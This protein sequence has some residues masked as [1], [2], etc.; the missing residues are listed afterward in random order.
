M[1]LN[2]NKVS[3]LLSPAGKEKA[4]EGIRQLTA[5]LHRFLRDRGISGMTD[6][7]VD[8]VL[9]TGTVVG[10]LYN[11]MF[12]V[13]A[14]TRLYM[15]EEVDEALRD[16]VRTLVDRGSTILAEQVTRIDHY[17]NLKEQLERNKHD[18]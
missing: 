13:E 18:R 17:K 1:I 9:A 11:V 12:E 10:A 4:Q 16:T 5:D 7:M 3:E 14:E 15:G 6:D 8:A 2:R